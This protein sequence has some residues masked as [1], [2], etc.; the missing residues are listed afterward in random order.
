MEN[1]EWL[2]YRSKVTGKS[3]ETIRQ[4]MRDKSQLAD[5]SKGGFA[6]LKL[7]NPEKLKE[8]VKKGGEVSKR[9]KKKG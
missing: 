6:H 4:E 8:I 2:R 5:K 7:N 9:G 1:S 3:I